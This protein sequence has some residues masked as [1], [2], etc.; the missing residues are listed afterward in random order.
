MAKY[1]TR[2]ALLK[3]KE[4]DAARAE[5]DAQEERMQH[6]EEVREL[7]EQLANEVS[8]RERDKEESKKQMEEMRLEFHQLLQQVPP[9]KHVFPCCIKLQ[10]QK[11][12]F[13]S[14]EQS[15]FSRIDNMFKTETIFFCQ[16]HI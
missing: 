7:K 12:N 9:L 6:Q 4:E 13:M 3:Q 1:P 8:A 14:I 2:R 10:F 15:I 16:C 11:Q 5:L